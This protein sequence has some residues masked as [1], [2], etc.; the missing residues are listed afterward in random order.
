MLKYRGPSG[1]A[2]PTI[3]IDG[4]GSTIQEAIADMWNR[5][6]PL[7]DKGY[8]PTTNVEIVNASTREV[9]ESFSMNDAEPRSRQSPDQANPD[10]TRKNKNEEHKPMLHGQYAFIARIRMEY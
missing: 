8:H 6:H 2:L 7:L 10:K 1:P 9:V 5:V 3:D 4:R